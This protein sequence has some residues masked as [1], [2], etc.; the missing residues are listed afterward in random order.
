MQGRAH[1]RRAAGCLYF[2]AA[3]LPLAQRW[4]FAHSQPILRD[5]ILRAA[6][7]AGKYTKGRVK[8]G[9]GEERGMVA[10]FA[11]ARGAHLDQIHQHAWVASGAIVN[12]LPPNPHCRMKPAPAHPAD[13]GA[14]ALRHLDEDWRDVGGVDGYMAWL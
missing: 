5:Q 1:T 12:N 2:N 13:A 3:G 8:V 7:A 4:T 6:E 11:M 9:G 10:G 14:M